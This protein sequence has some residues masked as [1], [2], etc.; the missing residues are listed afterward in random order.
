MADLGENLAL[1]LRK[2][3]IQEIEAMVPE[4]FYLKVTYWSTKLWSFYQLLQVCFSNQQNLRWRDFLTKLFIFVENISVVSVLEVAKFSMCSRNL[5]LGLQNYIENSARESLILYS[6]FFKR[7][8]PQILSPSP[9]LARVCSIF[10]TQN[11]YRLGPSS[12]KLY[13]ITEPYSFFFSQFSIIT[14]YRTETTCGTEN[15]FG[16]WFQKVSVHG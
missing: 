2:G 9:F 5:L 14:Q 13:I 16:P 15:N 6:F 3:V 8:H 1:T 4:E 11:I 10:V 7:W 12:S